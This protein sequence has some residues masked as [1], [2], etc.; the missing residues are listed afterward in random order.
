MRHQTFVLVVL[1]IAIMA[2]GVV[3]FYL[4]SSSGQKE[5]RLTAMEFGFNNYSGGPMLRVKTGENI[6]IFLENEGGVVHE[7]IVVK[8]LDAF[9]ND[10]RTAVKASG[11]GLT[12]DEVDKVLPVEMMHHKHAAA[13]FL[14]EGQLLHHVMVDPQ[15]TVRFRLVINRPGT[16]FYVCPMFAATFPETHADRGMFGVLVVEP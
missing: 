15:Q 12:S 4:L 10:L 1:S 7:F 6:I 2:T 5:L 9:L 3:S 8:D 13:M 14:M 16:Y 11:S